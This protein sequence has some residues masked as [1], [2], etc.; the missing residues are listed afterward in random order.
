[1]SGRT[2]CFPPTRGA[3][4]LAPVPRLADS[5]LPWLLA[6]PLACTAVSESAP[7]DDEGA[8][9]V[10]PPA[11]PAPAP[12]ADEGPLPPPP[13]VPRLPVPAP[14][15]PAAPTTDELPSALQSAC[16]VRR[17]LACTRRGD[18]DADGLID[19]V[20]LVRPRE[21]KALGLAVLWGRGGHAV[22]G[23]GVRGQSWRER[24]DE[25]VRTAKIPADLGWLADWDVLPAHGPAGARTGFRGRKGPVRVFKAPGVLGDGIYVSGGDAAAIVYWDGAGWRFEHLGF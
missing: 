12:S 21:G 16:E 9:R 3:S 22:L 13:E 4:T 20:A 15:A 2:S 8:G 18:L 10:A 24:V 1:M 5:V 17:K 11:L 25:S 14:P 19:T 6:A 23:A 7:A